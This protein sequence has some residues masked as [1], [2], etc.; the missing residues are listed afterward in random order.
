[1]RYQ[2]ISFFL[3]PVGSE[4]V[5]FAVI[6]SK[7]AVLIWP[8]CQRHR[9]KCRTG[10]GGGLSHQPHSWTGFRQKIS[11]HIPLNPMI[12]A[13]IWTWRYDPPHLKVTPWNRDPSPNCHLKHELAVSKAWVGRRCRQQV[14]YS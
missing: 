4:P 10:N 5:L 6:S 14:V 8:C 1:M 9:R 13:L 11:S 2:R 3:K 7:R 12:D